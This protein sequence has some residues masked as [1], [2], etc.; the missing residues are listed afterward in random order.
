[1]VYI[2]YTYQRTHFRDHD[3]TDV[4]NSASGSRNSIALSCPRT[5][6]SI[7]GKRTPKMAH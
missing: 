4:S 7:L 3:M 6:L 2:E 1:M 5:L